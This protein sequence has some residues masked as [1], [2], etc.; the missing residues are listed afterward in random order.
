[1]KTYEIGSQHI[2]KRGQRYE[3]VAHHNSVDVTVKFEDGTVAKTS[4]AIIRKGMVRNPTTTSINGIDHSV[5]TGDTFTTRDGLVC[6]VIG[7]RNSTD[8]DIMFVDSGYSTNVNACSVYNGVNL[9]DPYYKY[10]FDVGY[11]GTGHSVTTGSGENTRHY[12]IWAALLTRC[13]SKR[14]VYRTYFDCYV[15]EYL[16]NYS[17]F[18]NFVDPMEGFHL[19]YH[20]DKD[21]LVRG[22]KVYSRDTVSY[23]PHIINVAIQ[24][25]K[26]NRKLDLPAGVFYR[27]D[28]GKYRAISGEYGKNVNC[29]HFDDP[30]KAFRAYKES[31]EKY[32][33]ELAE[34]YKG[35]IDS[36]AYNALISYQVLPTD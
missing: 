28:N 32:L 11:T 24:G 9:R 19:G 36:R 17:N 2:N 22:N 18:Y 26:T 30:M 23:L 31:K 3:I 13:Y 21:L 4:N 27:K 16:H 7:Y 8:V 34:T 6:N 1:M 25:S 29:G 10:L 33:K 15:E 5:K 35:T 14:T 20:M 12:G